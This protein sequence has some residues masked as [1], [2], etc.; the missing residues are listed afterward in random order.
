MR[1]QGWLVISIFL[2]LLGCHHEPRNNPYRTRDATANIYY[3][4]YSSA[5]K[6]LDPAKAYTTDEAQFV[7]LV[8]EPPLQYQYLTRPW[9][10]EPLLA[11]QMPQVIYRDATGKIVADPQLASSSEYIVHIKPGIYYQPHPAFVRTPEGLHLYWPLTAAAAKS[12]TTA[13]DFKQSASREVTADDFVYEIKRLASPAVQSPIYGLMSTHIQ[14]LAT[15]RADLERARAQNPN[16]L[17][18]LRPYSFAGASVIDKYTYRIQL[19]D[20]YPQFMY[21]L[22][23]PFFAPYPW[24]ADQFYHNPG[25]E[26]HNITVDWVPIGTGPYQ[27]T[28]NNPNQSLQLIK[29]KNFHGEPLPLGLQPQVGKT[30][31]Y[32]DR[33]EFYLEKESIPRWNKFLQGYYDQSGIASDTFDE[34]ITYTAQKQPRINPKLA[35][36]HI[37]LQVSTTP[38]IFYLGFNQLDPVVGGSSPAA[39]QL[40]QALS[41]AVDMDEYIHLFL[42]G[43]G[44]V[45]Q[46]PLPP[47]IFGARTGEAG[48]DPIMYQWQQGRM[49]RRPLSD[50]KKLLSAAGYPDGMDAKTKRPLVLTLSIMSTSTIDEGTLYAWFRQQFAKLNIE[51]NI[52]ST[53]YSRFQDKLKNG[54]TQLFFAGWTADYPDPEN[55]L[56]LLYGPNSKVQYNG[57]NATNYHNPQFDSLYEQM[58]RLPNGAARQAIIDKM[59]AEVQQ[60]A[61]WIWGFYPVSFQLSQ[62]WVHNSYANPLI[63]NQLK[64]IAISPQTRY[65]AR[66]R[67]NQVAVW[68]IVCLVLSFM[69]F[70]G[71]GIMTYR[72]LNKRKPLVL[73]QEDK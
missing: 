55:F 1:I 30:I 5:P 42:N 57:E 15:L 46:G 25:F 11:S 41:I 63:N 31:P 12:Y 47:G 62:Q 20:P 50:A 36:K 53:T 24:E 9:T 45:A 73:P 3:G 27:F 29:N 43:R 49:K 33:I 7:S 22:A 16:A 64:Y 70:I 56:F 32:I 4:A 17:V 68:P 18:D 44:Q 10:L 69:L 66:L 65:Q 67:W 14:G 72:R 61:P 13:N 23:M 39:R 38:S 19:N 60:D 8:Y 54:S 52:E 71:L 26:D 37:S 40:R 51:L 59:I 6:T 58:T 28:Q 2:L 35:A 34:A 21:W 48:M